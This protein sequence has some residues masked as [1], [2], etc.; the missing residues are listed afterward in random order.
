[1]L[2]AAG[3]LWFSIVFQILVYILVFPAGIQRLI[4]FVY[5]L[6]FTL[7]IIWDELKNTTVK[8]IC[9]LMLCFVAIGVSLANYGLVFKDINGL[10]SDS[11]NIGRFISDNLSPDE[12]II[13]NAD[14]ATVAIM[15]YISNKVYNPV[16]RKPMTYMVQDRERFY[17][18]PLDEAM[19]WMQ[20]SFPDRDGVYLIYF[21]NGGGISGLDTAL[22]EI[23]PLY[24]TAQLLIGFGQSETYKLYYLPFD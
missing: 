19:A 18:V 8:S 22:A 10:F 16:I 2:K 13:T 14:Y 11:C 3:I 4:T 1:M 21:V 20:E 15:P 17:T 5:I 9:S 23:S 24:E 12:V 6:L 7:W